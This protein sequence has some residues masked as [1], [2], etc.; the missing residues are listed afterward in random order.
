[1]LIAIWTVWIAYICIVHQCSIMKR[2]TSA[3][4]KRNDRSKG[5]ADV[6]LKETPSKYQHFQWGERG[7]TFESSLLVLG[8]PMYI[9]IVI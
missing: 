1:M 4:Y 9:S 2:V 8:C 6:L 5:Y 3:M 7:V